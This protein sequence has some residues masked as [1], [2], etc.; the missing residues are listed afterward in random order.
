MPLPLI[1]IAAGTAIAAV[2]LARALRPVRIDQRAEDALDAMDEGLA[3]GRVPARGQG[4][5][6]ARLRRV[7]RF[8][9]GGPAWEV[10]AALLA[11]FRLRRV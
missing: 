9:S 3:A 6:T 4:S 10:D 5:A 11:R 2:A 7:I 8:G 1:P